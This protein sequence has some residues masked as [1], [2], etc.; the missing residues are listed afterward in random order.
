MYSEAGQQVAKFRR[1]CQQIIS[2]CIR[3][4][5][6]A[7]NALD[8][9]DAVRFELADL[10][11]IVGKQANSLDAKGVQRRS[12]KTVVSRIGEPTKDNLKCG[13]ESPV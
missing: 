8:H 6:L 12:A 3:P 2:R 5:W 7:G 4:A 9:F 11:G 10:I 13:A 1:F